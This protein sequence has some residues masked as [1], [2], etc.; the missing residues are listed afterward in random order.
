M[1]FIKKF[2]EITLKD[3]PVVGGKNASLGEMIQK[4]STKGV[5]VPSGFAIT[6]DAYR[7]LIKQNNLGSTIETLLSKAMKTDLDG[8]AAIGK[9][10]RK[11]IAAAPLPEEIIKEIRDAYQ[12]IEQRYGTLCD[13]AVRSSA[14]AEDL[15][16]ASFAGQQETFLN[17]RGADALLEACRKAYASL[18]TDRAISYRIDNKFDHMDVALSIGVQKMVRSDKGCSGVIF[19]LDT[20]SGFRDIVMINA[21]YGLGENIVQGTVI[22][23][24]FYVHKPTLKLGFKPVLKKRL[25]TKHLRMVYTESNGKTTENIPV[26]EAEQKKYSLTNDEIISLAQ[27]AMTIEDHYTELKGSWCPMD[28]EWGK[29]GAGQIPR[30]DR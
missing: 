15:P 14:T 26:P 3:L 21:S 22:P 11:L 13:V 25:G 5:S 28:I 4:L 10:I 27:Q 29:D 16:E 18:F 1:K 9:E 17:I 2:E 7:E 12:Q 19:T 30:I 8:L 20:E 6:A 23:D 24:E